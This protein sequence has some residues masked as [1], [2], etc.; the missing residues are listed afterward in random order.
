MADVTKTATVVIPAGVDPATPQTAVLT[1]D[2]YF[3]Q[4]NERK[5]IHVVNGGGSPTVC[6]VVTP[7]T[8]AG[9]AIAE[10][11]VTIPAGEER[12]LG[13]FPRSPYNDG[14]GRVSWSYDV[15]TSVTHSVIEI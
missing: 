9:L 4:N 14:T 1:A 10:L 5:M 6:T 13:P 3:F 12:F 2:V 8:I 11:A 15:Q 7:A